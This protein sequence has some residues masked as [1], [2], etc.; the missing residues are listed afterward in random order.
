MN[1][2]ELRN[3]L[4]RFAHENPGAVRN[5]LMT[6]LGSEDV[7]VKDH[8]TE[9]ETMQRC[10]TYIANEDAAAESILGLLFDSDGIDREAFSEDTRL[11]VSWCM[12]RAQELS[13]SNF[14]RAVE[15][16]TGTAFTQPVDIP[17]A[18]RGPLGV[19]E[20]VIADKHKCANENNIDLCEEYH[21]GKEGK[22]TGTVTKVT[23]GGLLVQFQDR[24]RKIGSPVLFDGQASGRKTGLYR[25][26]PFSKA[27]D[28]AKSRGAKG[29]MVELIYTKGGTKPPPLRDIE[30]FKQYIQNG[31]AKGEERTFNYYTGPI[32]KQTYNKKGEPY[33][34]MTAQQR[35]YPTSINPKIGKIW[36]M[37][38]L[39]GRPGGWRNDLTDGVKATLLGQDD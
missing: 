35:S 27:Q 25:H 13:S 22:I 37:G 38:R 39:G 5:N 4:I 30:K 14:E 3:A 34:M 23:S 7:E 36:Y 29:T 10:A 8:Y 31:L 20:P 15:K 17:K 24:G 9:E 32:V 16:L 11:F 12:S 21:A 1:D 33:F 26:T 18:K 6:I 28:G 2:R 19:G